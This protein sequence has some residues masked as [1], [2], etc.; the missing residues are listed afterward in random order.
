MIIRMS[1]LDQKPVHPVA[2]SLGA[3][4]AMHVLG[5]CIVTFSTIVVILQPILTVNQ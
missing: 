5:L 1:G 2:R 4:L 3:R